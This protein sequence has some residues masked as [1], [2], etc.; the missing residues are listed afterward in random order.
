MKVKYCWD[1]NFGS[2]ILHN[3]W[4]KQQMRSRGLNWTLSLPR[5]HHALVILYA[6]LQKNVWVSTISS[7]LPLVCWCSKLPGNKRVNKHNYTTYFWERHSTGGYHRT[8]SL[9]SSNTLQ[10]F[11]VSYPSMTKN[12][13]GI[14]WTSLADSPFVTIHTPSSFHN[15]RTVSRK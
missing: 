2:Q 9:Y 14:D 15:T 12:D 13:K 5:T 6:R 4:L 11:T 3:I 10:R 8:W 1:N 7:D